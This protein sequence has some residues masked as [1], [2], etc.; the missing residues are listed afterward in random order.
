[1][2]KSLS[3]TLLF[4]G[5]A[6]F[7]N[8]QSGKSQPNN[9][10]VSATQEPSPAKMQY[11]QEQNYLSANS[12]VG[13][14]NVY[15]DSLNGFNE[16]KIKH[17]LLAKGIQGWEA[18]IYLQTL[19]RDF[20]NDKYALVKKQEV[21][22][23]PIFNNNTGSKK[24]GLG[25]IIN[26]TPC[27][28]EDFELTP[29][30]TYAAI[31]SVAGWTLQSRL[32][33]SGGNACG[34]NWNPGS[35]TF[36]ILTTP[37]VWPI[38]GTIPHSPLGGTQ[39]ARLNNSATG[40]YNQTRLVQSF[41]VTN[42]NTLFQ[43][44]YAGYWQDGGGGH[45][46]CDQPGIGFRMYDC[47][48][49][50]LACSSLSL[51]PGIGCQSS[52][53]TYTLQG[54]T[55][56]W[57]NWQVKYIDLTPYIGGCVTIE[58]MTTDCAFG[59]HYG[60]TFFDSRCGGQLLANVPGLGG[61]GANIAG[62]VSFCA[63][64][65]IAQISAPLG[66][67]AYQW[68]SPI[69][70]TIPAPQGTM[71]TLSVQNPIPGTV[72]TVNL[73]SPSG[74]QY[75]ATNTIVFSQVN[76]AGIGSSS[77]CANGASG[78]AT[79]LGNGSGSGYNYTWVNST[80]SVVGTGSV[81]LNLAA[82]V[83][84]VTITGIG[85]AGC[86]SATAAT[87]VNVAPPG[88]LPLFKP[89]CGAQAFLITA[90][91]SNF[92][93]YNGMTPIPAIQGGNS[94]S[95]TVNPAVNGAIYRLSYLSS[96]GCQ[97]SV[98]YTLNAS[99]PGNISVQG[100]SWSCP[101]VNN[102]TAT[103]MMTPAAGA[104]PGINAFTVTNGNA[105]TPVYNSSIF[106]TP[107]NSYTV[108][109]LSAGNYAV[110]AFD[111][112]CRYTTNF[113]VS[114]YTYSYNLP[115][116]TT[117]CQGSNM[118]AGVTFTGSPPSSGQ[119]Q[120]TWTPTTFML[121]GTGNMQSTFIT[122]TAVP[123]QSAT[124]GYTVT[125][126][127]TAVNCPITKSF[128]VTIVNPPTPTISAIPNMCDNAA[129]Y[130]I[131][132]TPS[133]G[134]FSTGI[135]GTANPVSATGLISPN[136]SGIILGPPNNTFTYAIMVNICPATATGTYEV[137]HYNPATLTSSISPM[138]VN[139]PAF[140]LMNIVQ[141]TVNGT[142]SSLGGAGVTG[143]AGTYAFN[144]SNLSTGSYILTYS[145]T[146]SPNATVCPAS[147][148]LTV[149][150]TQTV[151]PSI[152]IP[153]AFCTNAPSFS[154]AASPAGGTWGGNQGLSAAGVITPSNLALTNTRV[155]YS[156]TIG[157]CVN[158]N[159]AN[160]VFSQFNPATL[161]GGIP[162]QCAKNNVSFNL[163]TIVQNTVNGTWHENLN[164]QNGPPIA[165]NLFN[166]T[167]KFTG[168]YVL[169][170]SRVSTPNPALCPD[171][172]TVSVS[173]LNPQIPV[174]SQVGPFC[175]KDGNVQ[176]TVNQ[177]N[178][179][180][181]TSAYLSSTGVLTPSL[182][183]IGNNPVQYIVGTNTCN[184]QETKFISVEAFVPA[185][186]STPIPDQCNTG[187]ATNLQPFTT[188][189]TGVWSGTGIAGTNFNP[190]IAGSGKFYLTYK[191]SSSPS[192]LCPDQSTIAVNVYSLAP[193]V[194][195]LDKPIRCNTE[196]PFQL[197]VSPVGGLFGGMGGAVVSNKGIVNPALGVIGD[198][199]ITYSVAVGPCIAYA[200]TTVVI[201]KFVSAEFSSMPK[202]PVYCLNDESFDMMEL[203]LN[204][205]GQWYKG[206]QQLNTSYFNPKDL[207]EGVHSF[208]YKIGKS[209]KHTNTLTV[210]VVA[211]P[212]VSVSS[213]TAQG[214]APYNVV[215]TPKIDG[216]GGT[217]TWYMGD[218]SEPITD[219]N[220][221]HTY[222]KAGTYTATLKYV[223]AEGCASEPT[224]VTPAIVVHQAPVANFSVPDE[225]Y[226]S[227]PEV[228]FTN[229]S[230][231][232]GDNRYQWKIQGMYS[233]ND[234]N[235]TVKFNKAGKYP[236]TL[237]AEP[238]HGACKTEITKTIEIKNDFNI[239]I[240]SSFSPNGDNLN[241]VFMP[242]FSEY[243]L[244]TKTYEMEIFDRWG[245][246]LFRTKDVTKGWDGT[247]NTKGDSIK[248]EVYIYKIKYKDVDGNLYSKIGHLSLVK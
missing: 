12:L 83:Y 11:V 105:G 240:P 122:P 10:G 28:N 7:S 20:I 71:A 227:N 103:I 94:S 88:V 16:M 72:Y 117:L 13:F 222:R 26:A 34:T 153:Q 1:M 84:S 221:S 216:T 99:T 43:F 198:N 231:S 173:V 101:G 234:V 233:L 111:G 63:G 185:T 70:G 39:V 73:T 137:S 152:V 113:N 133:G 201:E 202:K 127:P 220:V 245:H 40:D 60:T 194:I 54:A 210:K 156:V 212:K 66:Y 38:I 81:A 6:L 143:G 159:T 158:S 145:T 118:A 172:K 177:N 180:W 140:N 238:L 237:I 205:G 44:A 148:N 69:T 223:S 106:P 169:T 138:C 226:I 9:S 112:S 116:N 61:T 161:T 219:I 50:P 155:N 142:W 87:T 109:G 144:P 165:G 196:A 241:D 235:P 213:G 162:D 248:E 214:C 239:Y 57:T 22:N 181:S 230:T 120:Y 179:Q 168:T 209:C 108:G 91:G 191:T 188:S 244:D 150:V 176:L 48:G 17:E 100:I 27:V 247:I 93:W 203:T 25:A 200:Q 90:G 246:S 157:P 242:V 46:C 178:G 80:N 47:S 135:T 102:A 132:T 174:I 24:T 229:L 197:D 110:N 190:S 75:V 18:A 125:V 15:G 175:N 171:N 192:G 218:D 8:A 151:L 114:A 4:A 211:A 35:P 21:T 164:G 56:S 36:S 225:I 187:S 74:C 149:S 30:G 3:F 68:V 52:G 236:V 207:G 42:N 95:Y 45:G 97:D 124:I 62:P 160:L 41:P 98:E 64:S 107:F 217:A 215:L 58:V 49:N 32:A 129:P 228:Q 224:P 167:G 208:E 29:S 163:S 2:K 189:G 184:S 141:S 182:C 147:S 23:T 134:V 37:F 166:P 55:A 170:Y 232:L 85:A 76:I 104:P 19:K 77:T 92:R 126:T 136:A 195:N 119:Y 82:G 204:P 115:P 59:G 130:Q 51:F 53:V 31:N 78:S 146:S 67:A 89:F 139:N 206:T 193:P 86:G 128:S 154:L 183:A 199:M 131:N 5:L 14:K 79:V 96:Q 65:N 121:S 243:G 186:I 33:N 123:G